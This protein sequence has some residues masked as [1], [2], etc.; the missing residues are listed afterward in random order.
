[1]Y[2]LKEKCLTN[3]A[4]DLVK[5]IDNLKDIWERLAARYG[6]NIQIVDHT[7]NE[8]HLRSRSLYQW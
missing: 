7:S 1:M 8:F 5:N 3:E 4:R 6:D 2:I